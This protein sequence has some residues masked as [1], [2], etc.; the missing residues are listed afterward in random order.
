MRSVLVRSND[1][2]SLLFSTFEIADVLFG[3]Q[4][5]Q[6]LNLFWNWRCFS[7][8]LLRWSSYLQLQSVGIPMIIPMLW[9]PF[10]WNIFDMRLVSQNDIK[11]GDLLTEIETAS[12]TGFRLAVVG[13]AQFVYNS[14][15]K[16]SATLRSTLWGKA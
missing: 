6:Y 4:F 11:I 1:I 7:Y 5:C 8:E 15:F 16:K 3:D 14:I 12:L 10:G 13:Q 9:N 2:Q